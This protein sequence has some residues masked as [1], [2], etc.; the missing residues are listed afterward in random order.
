M[1]VVFNVLKI[2]NFRQ[3]AEREFVFD[4][5]TNFIIGKNGSGK[6]NTLHA[7]TWLLF[8]KDLDDRSKFAVVPLNP[9]NTVTEL[10]PDVELSM[11]I[12]GEPHTV[13]RILR[14]GSTAQTFIDDMP[15]RTLKE[16]DAFVAGIF[17]T[18]DRFKIY[19]NPL[20]FP[21]MNWREQRELFMQFFPEP[22]REAVLERLT[23]RQGYEP[24]QSQELLNGNLERLGDKLAQDKKEL[25]AE[26]DKIRNQM[27]LLDEQ[28][29]GQ[30]GLDEEKLTIERY[31][32]REKVKSM[33]DVIKMAVDHNAGIEKKRL[34]LTNK[35]QNA[36]S[37]MALL[38]ENAKYQRER[39][40]QALGAEIKRLE[41]DRMRLQDAYVA[42]KEE[43]QTCQACGQPLPEESVADQKTAIQA[44]GIK[45]A[46]EIEDKQKDL[47]DLKNQML[48]VPDLS[49]FINTADRAMG[50]LSSLDDLIEVPTLDDDMIARLDELDRTLARAD[51]HKENIDRKQKLT[52]RLREINRLFE[53]TEQNLRE[54]A[55]FMFYRS[56]LIVEAVN[57]EFKSISVKVL[58]IQ[59]NGVA[60]ETFEILKDGVPFVE[61]NT[62][63]QL[64]A[65]LE[66][67]G[68]IKSKLDI[69]C[70]VLIDNG[71]RFTDL[72][73]LKIKGQLIATKAVKGSP[74]DVAYKVV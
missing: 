40:V 20:H 43:A 16:F 36:L 62:A 25:E 12:N 21:S 53:E 72:D 46:T 15:C 30:Q 66:L 24:V 37:E 26:R 61:L 1:Q 39:D 52:D 67:A 42:L 4:P 19:T 63:G 14:G 45:L 8:G 23:L 3:I 50:E 13:R 38:K 10:E 60:K 7:I 49:E 32:L 68:F 11:T 17:Q 58:E 57:K 71:E 5:K 74:L 56:E 73:L 2:R 29:E 18:P 64:E 51:V 44:K 28:L 22:P 70:P 55:D 54:V 27:E 41:D 47:D 35:R 6:T 69:D 34:E 31:E 33:R 65:G 9:D 59:K 48:A